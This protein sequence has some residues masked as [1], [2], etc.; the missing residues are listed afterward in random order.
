MLFSYLGTLVV[1]L[2]D[3]FRAKGARRNSTETQKSGMPQ[4]LNQRSKMAKVVLKMARRR[5]LDAGQVS[6]SAA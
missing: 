5:S 3:P 2:P 4:G 1:M 6:A